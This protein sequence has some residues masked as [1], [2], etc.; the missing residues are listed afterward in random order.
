M[1]SELDPQSHFRRLINSQNDPFRFWVA[2]SSDGRIE[3]WQ[4]LM[5][6]RNNPGLV[7]SMAES[8]TYVRAKAR[9]KGVGARLLKQATQ[10]AEG[11]PLRFLLAFVAVSNAPMLTISQNLGWI[12][13]ATVP[14][15]PKLPAGTDWHLLLYTVPAG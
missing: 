10:H 2:L 7:T 12:V 4:S 14:C 15:S 13:M 9:G 1:D 3:G 8:S 6:C 11:T 5:P